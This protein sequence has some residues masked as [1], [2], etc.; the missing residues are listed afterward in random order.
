MQKA[1]TDPDER[2]LIRPQAPK[3]PKKPFKLPLLL[4][5][6][7]LFLGSAGGAA[8]YFLQKPAPVSI[9][10]ETEAQIDA[11]Q[12]CDIKV[13]YFAPDPRIV[14]VDFPNLT[15]QGLML[16]RVAALIEKAKLPR[17]KVLDDVALRAAIYDCGDTIE[18]YYYG[19]D[20]RAADLAR[21]FA[22][23]DQQ[24]VQLN[25]HELW[26]KRLLNQLGW[27]VPGANGALITLPAAAPPITEEMRAVILHHELSHGAFFTNPAYAAYAVAFWGSLTP[28]EQEGFKNFLGGEGYDTNNTNLMLNETQ[29]YLIFTRDP[30]FFNAH[31]VGMS[32]DEKNALRDRFIAGMPDFWLKPMANADLPVGNPGNICAAN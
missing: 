27:L 15:I 8:W 12:P 20:Y 17:N 5:V 24:G 26:L 29:A 1:G 16:D 6:V 7:L 3:P 21:F 2:V 9:D 22:L 11:T 19:H 4:V 13:S 25:P 14:V 30:Q 23:A 10:T 18:S 32:D 31:A 28:S